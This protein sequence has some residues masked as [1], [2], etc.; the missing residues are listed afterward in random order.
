MNQTKLGF[1]MHD[2]QPEQVEVIDTRNDDTMFVEYCK[3]CGGEKG[4]HET[5]EERFASLN[6]A[7][8]NLVDGWN[9]WPSLH[10]SKSDK[11]AF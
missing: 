2:F 9:K 7:L 5:K 1:N 10:D 4:E 11:L 8:N 6:K 3:V